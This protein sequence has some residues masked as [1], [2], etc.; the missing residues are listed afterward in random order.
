[1]GRPLKIKKT[2]TVDIGFNSFDLLTNPVYPAIMTATEYFG[3]TG[4]ANAS[5]ATA[6]YPVTKVNVFIEG[7]SAEEEGVILRQKGASKYLVL[8]QTTGNVGVCVLANETAGNITEGNMSIAM[9]ADDSAEILISKL[10]NKF[11]LDYSNPPVRY[12]VNFFTDG[13][14]VIKSG[15]TGASNTSGQ[16]N[17]VTLTAVEKYTS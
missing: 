9:S 10:T 6:S 14:T 16:Q 15:T 13:D 17:L 12:A 7:E 8:G 3:V 4:G 5:V 2:T 11:A 1:M